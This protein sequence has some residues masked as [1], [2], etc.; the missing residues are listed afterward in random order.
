M[1]RATSL[2]RGAS[3]LNGQD[4]K[5]QE[6]QQQQSLPEGG[7]APG[8]SGDKSGGSRR[9]PAAL[10]LLGVLALGSASFLLFKNLPMLDYLIS[11]SGWFETQGAAGAVLFVLGL[12]AWIVLFLP[13]TPV[14][15]LCAFTYGFWWSLPLNTLGKV[16]G[17]TSAFVL[18]RRLGGARVQRRFAGVRLLRALERAIARGGGAGTTGGAGGGAAAGGS[19]GGAGSTTPSSGRFVVLLI[20]CAFVPM[21]V[22]NYGLSVIRAV[23]APL[24]AG[25]CFL[26]GFPF[27]V[28]LGYVGSTARDLIGVLRGEGEVGAVQKIVMGVGGG[29]LVL[30]VCLL[31]RYIR[32]ALRELD[33]EE[34]EEVGVG[35]EGKGAGV[36]AGGGGG[37]QGGAGVPRLAVPSG[38]LVVLA[39]ARFSPASSGRAAG[40]ERSGSDDERAGRGVGEHVVL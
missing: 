34:E 14:E 3:S 29:A 25:T 40:D 26:A 6:Q 16:C 17:G 1:T 10:I 9:R 38:A 37:G 28:A 19:G 24:F 32:R 21:W 39:K 23:S 18:G 20:Q 30:C 11:A 35:E 13:S 5:P 4:W 12:M 36:G 33:D 8:S 27:T 7:A 22:K 2:G 31:T 15:L